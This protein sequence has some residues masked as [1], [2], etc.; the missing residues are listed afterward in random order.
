MDTGRTKCGLRAAAQS[1][2]VHPVRGRV[3]TPPCEWRSSSII[4]FIRL[5]PVHPPL[6]G[7]LRPAQRGKLP[8]RRAVPRCVWNFAVSGAANFHDAGL[9]GAGLGLCR[10]RRGELPWRRAVPRR[11]GDFAANPPG[12]RDALHARTRAEGRRLLRQVLFRQALLRQA[13]LPQGAVAAGALAPGKRDAR[14]RKRACATRP[15][16]RLPLLLDRAGVGGRARHD[17]AVPGLPRP[18]GSPAG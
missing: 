14:A 15:H 5:H 13:L 1:A 2:P 9:C 8:R 7:G 11:V 16:R 6:E 12:G 10:A 4:R 17:K 18:A 3:E